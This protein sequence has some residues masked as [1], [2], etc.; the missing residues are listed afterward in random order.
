MMSTF[1]NCVNLNQ[2]IRIP[3][4][5]TNLSSTFDSCVSLNQNI[6]IPNSVTNM[7]YTFYGCQNLTNITVLSTELSNTYYTFSGSGTQAKNVYIYFNYANGM[8]TNTYNRVV[9]NSAG[10]A[11][12][13]H[14]QYGVTVYNLGRAPW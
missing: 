5:V 2:N 4:N 3:N 1:S 10:V 13:W 9:A 12:S 11:N 7:A 6:R 8:P 14:Q